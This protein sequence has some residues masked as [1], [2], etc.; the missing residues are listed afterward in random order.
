MNTDKSSTKASL[1]RETGATGEWLRLW[2]VVHRI[3]TFLL[4]VS[5]QGLLLTRSRAL[6]N[7]SLT[8]AFVL[9]NVEEQTDPQ[10]L[11]AEEVFLSILAP[12]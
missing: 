4:F 5:C 12:Y 1:P 8:Q 11:N 6:T 3:V 9:T 10:S 7:A 2:P